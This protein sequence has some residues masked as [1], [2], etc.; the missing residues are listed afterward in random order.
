MNATEIV[1]GIL[2]GGLYALIGLGLSLVFGVLRLM[3]LAYAQLIIIGAYA[4]WLIVDHTGLDPLVALPFAM[5]VTALIAYPFQRFLLT[6]L[7]RTSITAPLVATFGLALLAQAGLQAAFGINEKSIPAPYGDSGV[8]VLGVQVQ[9]VY[10][11]AFGLAGVLCLSAHLL[12]MRTRIGSA[13]RAAAADP[14]TAAV[15]GLDVGRIYA[16]TFS[17][18]AAVAAAAG[19]M[20]GVAQSFTAASG[21][22]LLL[23]GFA[24]MALGGIGSVGGT[25]AAGISL[26]LLQSVSVS[27]FGAGYQNLAVYLT[28]FLVLAF[29]PTGVFRRVRTT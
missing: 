6:D 4:A 27:A 15:L 13:V 1:A 18:S 17:F 20:T 5:A 26:G 10:L 12:L 16:W 9:S 3:N 14:Q 19:V 28:F 24:V 25:F 11:I 7:L 8:S 2:A 29:R 23:T 21:T 22:P